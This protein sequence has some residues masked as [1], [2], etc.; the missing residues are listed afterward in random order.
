MLLILDTYV[1]RSFGEILEA[2]LCENRYEK[3]KKF[4]FHILVN[5]LFKYLGFNKLVLFEDCF[6]LILRGCAI[7]GCNSFI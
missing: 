4:A 1:I 7:H 6:F 2:I 3:E 5:N